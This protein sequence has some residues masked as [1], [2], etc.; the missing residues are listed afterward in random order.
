MSINWE[1]LTLECLFNVERVFLAKQKL[2]EH[3]ETYYVK[4]D[5]LTGHLKFKTFQ[6]SI[7]FTGYY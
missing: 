5:F 3:S 2:S 7:A 4:L 1:C 6:H